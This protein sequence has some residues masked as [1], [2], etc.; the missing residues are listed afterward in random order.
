MTTTLIG[1]GAVL[2]CTT[3]ERPRV[4]WGT[5]LPLAV[6]AGFGSGF[7]LVAMRGAVGAIERTSGPFVTWLQ[8]STLLLPLYVLAVLAAVTLALR[9]FGPS[10][11]RPRAVAVTLLLVVVASTLVA[12]GVQ[13]ASAVY[14]YQLQA[15]HLEVMASHGGCDAECLAAREESTLLLQVRALGLGGLVML[16][17]NLVVLSLVVAF[18]GGRLNITS[19]RH[20]PTRR[21][22]VE[23]LLMVGLLGAAAIH[24]TV[25]GEHFAE[26]PAAGVFF[27]LLTLA[28]LTAAGLVL[29]RLRSPAI[30]ATM[31]VSAG[32][33][34]LWLYSRSVGLPFGPEAGTPEHIGLADLAALLLEAATLALAF[35]LLRWRQRPPRATAQHLRAL[36]VVAM[37]ATTVAGV[38]GGLGVIDGGEQHA[39]SGHP[40]HNL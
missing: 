24:A 22:T 9:W 13:A 11:L 28:Q 16:V 15:A 6:V 26:W 35:A 34:L 20:H 31:V 10:P 8:E 7:W 30:L 21:P 25:I 5:V 40:H 36:A 18:R 12:I 38:A 4:P 23:V 37:F 19:P 29:V 1:A 27:V 32:P 2:P 3:T 33:L 39:Q 14:D 17:S